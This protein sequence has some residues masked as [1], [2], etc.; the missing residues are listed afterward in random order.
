MNDLDRIE[1]ALR[2]NALDASLFERCAQDLLTARY[3]NLTPIPGGSDWGQDGAISTLDGAVRL[4]ATSSR[5]YEGVRKNML[6][7]IESMRVHQVDCDQ[8]VL[9]NAAS[10][11]RSHRTKLKQAAI[12]SEIK[13]R[14]DEIYDRG[15]FASRLRRDPYWRRALLGLSAT[16][17]TLSNKAPE[18][19]ESAW[20]FL[21]LVAR[22]EDLDA[23]ASIGSDVIVSAP[24][25]VGKS[26]LLSELTDVVFIDK[27]AQVDAILSDLRW[28]MPANV[29]VDDS[30]GHETLI[31]SLLSARQAEPDVFRFNVIAVCWP[32]GRQGLLDLLPDARQH[33]LGFVERAQIDKLLLEMQISGRR[34]RLEILRQ[35]E[36][37]PG[38]AIALG[39]MLLHSGD[40]TSLLDGRALLGQVQSYLR[41]A[42]VENPSTGLLAVIATLRGITEGDIARL[43]TTVELSR[44]SAAQLLK[45]AAQSG[46][47]DVAE[48]YDRGLDRAVRHYFVRPQMLAAGLAA[49]CLFEQEFP[50]TGVSDLL[51]DWPTR[52]AEITRTVIDAAALGHTRARVEARKLLLS[53]LSDDNADYL[54]RVELCAA[55]INVDRDAADLVVSEARRAL[56]GLPTQQRSGSDVEPLIRLA[57]LAARLYE[58]R[59]AVG[60]LLDSCLYDE[61]ATNPNPDHPL[62]AVSELISRFDPE[63]ER[64]IS[65]RALVLKALEE[66]VIIGEHAASHRG[67]QVIAAVIGALLSLRL[68]ATEQDPGAYDRVHLFETIP[69][70]VEIDYII[71]E[72]WPFAKQMLQLGVV[73]V[74]QELVNATGEW[75]RIGGGY[76]RPFG[77]EHRRDS[78]DAVRSASAKLL[79]WARRDVSTLGQKLRLK[80]IAELHGHELELPDL[81]ELGVFIRSYDSHD[82]DLLG[83]SEA[84]RSELFALGVDWASRDVETTLERIVAIQDDLRV[85]GL[86]WPDR[87]GPLF[88]GLA[89][90]VQDPI[91]WFHRSRLAGFTRDAFSFIEEAAKSDLVAEDLVRSMLHDASLR[92]YAVGFIVRGGLSAVPGAREALA[93]SLSADDVGP[94]SIS[95]LR[96]EI[97]DA[98]LRRYLDP[99]TASPR[100]RAIFALALLDGATMSGTRWE[101]GSL[102]DVWSGAIAGLT[103]EMLAGV[104][105]E[106]LKRL[107]LVLVAHCPEAVASAVSIYLRSFGGVEDVPRL[108]EYLRHTLSG[109]SARLKDSIWLEFRHVAWAKLSVLA[110]LAGS[111]LPWVASLMDRN[112][113]EPEVAFSYGFRLGYGLG[114]P[115]PNISALARTFLPR[116]ISAEEIASI[117]F[118]GVFSGLHSQRYQSLVDEFTTMLNDDLDDSVR[119]VALAGLRIFG[120]ARDRAVDEE[121]DQRVRG[122]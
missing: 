98:E 48:K 17:V 80:R 96:G 1:S 53:Y 52:R 82:G 118:N 35:A 39:G 34:A 12:R 38:W 55:Y 49:D 60:M 28:A 122:R 33:E 11:T 66:W 54:Q 83:R 59:S 120:D 102:T 8:I 20:A 72:V 85:G 64:S 42:G 110:P 23:F 95:V 58:H 121:R 68:S 84:L 19:A 45:R 76:D 92:P 41:R 88:A 9:A 57:T 100:S 14:E 106:R 5:T 10:L 50:T 114:A 63:I 86:E 40:A 26:R 97:P 119:A 61:R 47:L 108:P 81:G 29:V 27:Y 117:R 2:D 16:P 104:R 73:E 87:I 79:E 4:I 36:G 94:L 22:Q 31:R 90:A 74:E 3:P 15:F 51:R 107:M 21:P 65:D 32:D 44:S 103:L 18:I 25:G 93:E 111:D 24:A 30:F 6:R 105:V 13:L 89:S 75:L 56:E 43:A 91:G 67:R 99:A 70:P 101:S 78:V 71:A 69:A 7:S 109:L 77:N 37:R 115:R 116:G 112:L 46:L 113:V 62:R